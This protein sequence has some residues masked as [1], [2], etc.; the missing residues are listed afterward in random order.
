MADVFGNKYQIFFSATAITVAGAEIT[1]AE[2]RAATL[3]ID[4]GQTQK[5]SIGRTRSTSEYKKRSGT[6]Q[7]VGAKANS[8]S[9]D[10]VVDHADPLYIALLAK[11]NSGAAIALAEAVKNDG[12]KLADLT[13]F[14]ASTS[15]GIGGNWYVTGMGE[16][17]PEDGVVTTA[18]TLTPVA[19]Q[20]VDLT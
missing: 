20:V 14:A 16:E 7:A 8:M 4:T 15:R 12:T 11:Y 18:V 3:T 19:G 13:A 2:V 9:F 17:H 6:N 10:V 5:A 1:A